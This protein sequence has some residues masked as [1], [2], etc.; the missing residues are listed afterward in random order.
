MHLACSTYK[1]IIMNF[2]V[3]A[4]GTP[5]VVNPLT[6]ASVVLALPNDKDDK[7]NADAKLPPNEA[8]EVIQSLLSAVSCQ[9]SV[10]QASLQMYGH[11]KIYFGVV[12]Y[13]LVLS[14]LSLEGKFVHLTT[15]PSMLLRPHSQGKR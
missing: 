11:T 14:C 12:V 6:A 13:Y 4:L 7:D 2:I 9:S 1:F 5:I 15:P 10:Y 3:V 8:S